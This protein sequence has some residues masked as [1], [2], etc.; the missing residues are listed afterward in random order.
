LSG[1]TIREVV[2]VV[3]AVD[4]SGEEEVMPDA[5]LIDAIGRRRSKFTLPGY[6]AGRAPHNIGDAIPS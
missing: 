2:R 1:G 6:L 3:R 5:V 4:C